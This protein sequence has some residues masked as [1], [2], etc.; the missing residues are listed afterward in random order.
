MLPVPL[1]RVDTKRA[2]AS[3]CAAIEMP[4]SQSACE[5]PGKMSGAV[6]S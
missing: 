5:K 3:E 6:G 4:L 1:Q 2:S